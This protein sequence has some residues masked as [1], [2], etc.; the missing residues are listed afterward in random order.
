MLT[1]LHLLSAIALLIWFTHISSMGIMRVY[2]AN[3]RSALSHCV[4]KL[5]LFVPELGLLPWGRV[6]MLYRD[7]QNIPES[8]TSGRY[9]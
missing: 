8:P 1:L 3:L 6:V 4:K 9:Y 7:N 5:S 2:E